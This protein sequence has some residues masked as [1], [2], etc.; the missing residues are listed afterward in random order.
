MNQKSSDTWYVRIHDDVLAVDDLLRLTTHGKVQVARETPWTWVMLT[1]N[2]EYAG[3]LAATLPGDRWR[4][5]E[6]QLF[7][8]GL[9]VPE[10][11][12][13][14]FS[15]SNI[16]DFVR[17]QLPRLKVAA[18][19]PADAKIS[20]QLVRGGKQK[21]CQGLLVDLANLQNWMEVAPET[22]LKGLRWVISA[23]RSR[24]LIIGQQL[25]PVQGLPMIVNQNVVIPAGFQWRPEITVETLRDVFELSPD[26]WLLWEATN[27]FCIIE[28]ELLLNLTRASFRASYKRMAVN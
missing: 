15:W 27:K 8:P 17:L 28:D 5:V 22:R 1:E 18:R 2:A 3:K 13:P 19:Y 12:V 26:Q 14:R 9:Q 16:R 4:A 20:L 7:R 24:C 6:T 21:D 11:D 10:M 25:P 23:D